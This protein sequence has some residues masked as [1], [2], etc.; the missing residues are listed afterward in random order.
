MTRFQPNI[1][2]SIDNLNQAE[3]N[4]E[5]LQLLFDEVYVDAPDKIDA[6]L[7]DNIETKSGSSLT[8]N[9]TVDNGKFDWTLQGNCE[10]DSYTGK[11]LFNPNNIKIGNIST[12]TGEESTGNFIITNDYISVSPS[13]AYALQ[14]QT[15]Q[16]EPQ[17]VWYF[18]GQD[19]TFISADAINSLNSTKTLSSET[20]Y[21]K[22]RFKGLSGDLTSI[23]N[24]QLESGSSATSYEPYVGGIPSPNPDYPQDIRVVTGD[25]VITITNEDSSKSQTFPISLDAIELAGIGDY[26]DTI[27]GTPNNWKIVKNVG[28]YTFTGQENFNENTTNNKYTFVTW[29]NLGITNKISSDYSLCSKFIRTSIGANDTNLGFYQTTSQVRFRPYLNYTSEEFISIIDGNIMYYPLATPQE[30]KILDS[31]LNTELNTLYNTAVAYEDKTLISTEPDT[32]N[33][34]MKLSVNAFVTEKEV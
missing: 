24:V 3:K 32:G 7:E 10:Q 6:M 31:T 2:D 12:T 21:I 14:Y 27:E 19:K 5:K 9:N 18:Y 13:T 11:N 34:V 20:Y 25:N 26:V 1:T 30:T 8:I 4:I 33:A 22:I 28:K 23:T 16:E 29:V 15:S 17:I